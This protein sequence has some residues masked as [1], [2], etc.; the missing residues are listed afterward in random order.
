MEMFL[1]FHAISVM[2]A[3]PRSGRPSMEA[4]VPEPVMWMAEKPACSITF[5]LSASYALG[6]TRSSG[7]SIRSLNCLARDMRSSSV[8]ELD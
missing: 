7:A 4:D 2:V 1:A 6:T 3:K 8:N 5:A